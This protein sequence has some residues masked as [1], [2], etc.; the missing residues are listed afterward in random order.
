MIDDYAQAMEL[1]RQMQSQL[2]ILAYPLDA[3]VQTMRGRGITLD[4]KQ[5]LSIK[6]VV[7][8]GDEGGIMCDITPAGQR[9]PILCSVT[10]IQIDVHHL[11]SEPIRAY[12][13]QRIKRLAESGGPRKPVSFTV[14]PRKKG[15]R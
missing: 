8:L 11:L 2:P 4:P 10:H 15:R 14:K 7:Y 6:S 12:Q 9:N 5:A 3:L 13:R 1:V